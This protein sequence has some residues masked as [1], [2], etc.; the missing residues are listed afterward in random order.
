MPG[1]GCRTQC[2]GKAD[3]AYPKSVEVQEVEDS[4]GEGAVLNAMVMGQALAQ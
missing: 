3:V 4:I 1:S 2:P